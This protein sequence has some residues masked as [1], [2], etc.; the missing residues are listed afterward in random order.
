MGVSFKNIVHG[1]TIFIKILFPSGKTQ[2]TG[3]HLFYVNNEGIKAE[4]STVA[5]CNDPL[6]I[7]HQHTKKARTNVVNM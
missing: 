5:L 7:L 4:N 1:S 3:N 2:S 6:I